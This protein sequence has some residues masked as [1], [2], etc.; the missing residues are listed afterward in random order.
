MII[1]CQ[2]TRKKPQILFL[3]CNQKTKQKIAILSKFNLFNIN[4]SL[5][6]TLFR[7]YD[8]FF[9]DNIIHDT[10]RLIQVNIGFQVF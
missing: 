1:V 6:V 7:P 2:Y 8:G 10:H 9:T 3:F 5:F 4:L